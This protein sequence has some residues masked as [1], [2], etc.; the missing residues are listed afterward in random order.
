MTNLIPEKMLNGPELVKKG[1]KIGKTIELGSNR[2]ETERKTSFLDWYIT[3]TVE[4]RMK[5]NPQIGLKTLDETAQACR[6]LHDEAGKRGIDLGLFLVTSNWLMALPPEV[7]EKAPK[8][9]SFMFDSPEDFKKLSHASPL[10]AAVGDHIIAG[11]NSVRNTINCLEGGITALGTVSQFSWRYPYWDDEV[12]QMAEIVK[13]MGIVAANADKGATISTYIGDGIPGTFAD[14][15]NLV[16][17]VLLEQYIT[18]T[19]CGAPYFVGMGGLMSHLPNKFATMLAIDE[20]GRIDGMPVMGHV[21]GNT[22][23]VTQD[24]G[25]NYGL[26][27]AD[28]MVYALIERKYKTGSV[29]TAKPVTEA[30]QVPTVKEVLDIMLA[31][32]ATMERVKEIEEAGLFDDTG[33]LDIK[34]VLVREGRKFYENVMNG[35]PDLGVD[36]KDPLQMLLGLRRL[37]AVKL[38]EMF[39]PG[40]KDASRFQGIVPFA[41]TDLIRR[42]RKMADQHVETMSS[43][44]LDKTVQDKTIILGSADT[45][46]FALWTIDKVLKGV[47]ARVINGGVDMDPESFLDLARKEQ[48]AYMAVSVHNGQCMGWGSRLMAEAKKRN[49]EIK[50]FMGGVLNTVV[51]A[52]P[53]PVDAKD[54]LKELGI[55]PCTDVID[56]AEKINRI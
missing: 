36:T 49:Q 16:G 20:I 28:F 4:G 13:A 26:Q 11:P 39:H 23:E 6:W 43:R 34:A 54:M 45:H 32:H 37:G 1:I 52:S 41:E 18:Q 15:A 24:L 51:G 42:C 44:G 19:L 31:C 7:R 10:M 50:P 14:Y 27:V 29:Y 48:T 47:G 8:G 5:F 9:T 55:T 38:E 46:E 21:E 25:F 2:F 22:V 40:K 53:E 56:L 17:Y 35:L 12:A 33:I 3:E 30:I